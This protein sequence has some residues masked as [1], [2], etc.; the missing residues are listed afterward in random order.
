[1]RKVRAITVGVSVAVVVS[2]LAGGFWI[3]VLCGAV[4]AATVL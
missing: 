2:I 1:M 4:S 3:P